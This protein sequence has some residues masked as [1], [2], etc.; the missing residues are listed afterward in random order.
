MTALNRKL[1]RDLGHMWSQALAICLVM[2]C[3]IAT[4][5][6]SLCTLASL[7]QAQQTYYDR[8]RFA[9]VFAHLKRAPASLAE[10][11]AELPGVGQV[12]TRIVTDV[13]LDVPGLVEP[14]VGRLVS[15]PETASPTL[16]NL[17]LRQGRL[18]EKGRSG[19]VV[20]GEA[21]A[22]AHRLK[23]GDRIT[24]IL[25][26]RKQ[27]LRIVGIA[28]SPEYVY[29]IR[30]GEM[31]PDDKRYGVFWM[32]YTQ[33]AA[34]FD[35]DGAF[36]DV[37]LTLT[38]GASEPEVLRRLDR[39][40]EPYGGIGAFGRTDQVSHKFVDNEMTQL[41]SMALIPPAIFLSVTTFLLNV[42]LARL[43]STQ[44]EQI[45]T[46]R[47]FGY[48][49]WEIGWHYLKFVT[50]L[51][52]FG[53]ILGTVLGAWLGRGLTELYTRFFRFPVFTFF[54]D[55]GV[56]GLAFGLS[57]CA[58]LLG[59]FGA[60]W[61]ASR[62]P[63]AEA[64]RPEP[65]AKYRPSL[66]ERLGL[67]RFLSSTM[68]MIVRQLERWPTKA[69]LTV[70]GIALAV[71][72]LVLGNFV[73]DSVDYVIDFQ[74]FL[75]Q[76]QDVS[77]AFVEPTASRVLHEVQHLPGVRRVEPYRS[78]PARLRWGHRSRRLGILGLETRPQ[79][80]RLIDVAES[81]IQLPADGVVL[82]AKLAEVLNV[83]IGDKVVV[84]VLEGERPV[85]EVVVAG[86]VRDFTTLGAYMALPAMH[87][88]MREADTL[89]GTFLAVD[90]QAID[91]LYR[92]LKRTPKVA[93]VNIKRAALESFQKTLAENLLRMKTFNVIF[94]SIIAFGVVYNSARISLSERGRELATLRVIGFTRT[95]ISFILLGELALLT[96][97]A[98]PLGLLFGYG[99]SGLAI[100]ALE[101]ETQRF[102]LVINSS[103]YA[104][105]A[106]VTM[107]AALISGL[108][109]RRRVNQLDLVAVLKSRE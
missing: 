62:L 74:F 68:R 85:R 12:Q 93:N 16:N 4:F 106:T 42:V 76:R 105:A 64:M 11:I 33:L 88:M 40:T 18:V 26:G 2:A 13:T 37:A 9:H 45:A 7:E 44:R 58:A 21:F 41:R 98:L 56:V 73:V 63:P 102:P 77:I 51:A 92:K 6:M 28:L 8:Y 20:V 101:T 38:P 66:L 65:P 96:L 19:E 100:W 46:L 35:M 107:V 32:G 3:G 103:T 84:E 1:V 43:I 59:T 83:G 29:S 97:I 27:S 31:L 34:A 104:F 61:R 87:R 57:T 67:H 80:F 24:A 14:A 89:S 91:Q 49:R 81:E 48:T 54:L 72:V 108:I 10:R 23:P 25:N 109:V 17:H 52:A 5:V 53:G 78:L 15:V 95:E 50:L 69:L 99:L 82:S 39:L 47:A 70:T 22:E 75:A 36:N 86:L 71:G 60:I 55:A 94:A 30:E 79:L 90:G